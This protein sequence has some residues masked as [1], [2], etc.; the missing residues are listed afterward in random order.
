MTEV[1]RGNGTVTGYTYD[2]K[3]RMASLLTTANHNGKTWKVQ[4]VK[5]Q[6]KV[7]NSVAVVQNTPDVA[8]D[9]AC[10]TSVRYEYSYDGLNRLV[11]ARGSYLKTPGLNPV[12]KDPADGIPSSPD[13]I[14]H[15]ERGSV[16]KKY[17][18]GYAYVR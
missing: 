12:Q 10:K 13:P 15:G 2:I 17:E 3:G 9:G 18:L 6:F 16:S 7:D 8:A 1:R 14:S 11:R 4:D 5:Y